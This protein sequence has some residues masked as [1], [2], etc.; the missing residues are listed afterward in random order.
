M[1]ICSEEDEATSC[2]IS[3]IIEDVNM[4]GVRLLL[5]GYMRQ[6]AV[7]LNLRTKMSISYMLHY[8]LNSFQLIHTKR[9]NNITQEKIMESK[10][11]KYI[12]VGY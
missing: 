1:P 3:I 8:F 5:L 9:P 10:L 11:P 7:M 4:N 12:P 2:V 6:L